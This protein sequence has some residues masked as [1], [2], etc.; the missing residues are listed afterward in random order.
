M[1]KIYR[2]MW[3][4]HNLLWGDLHEPTILLRGMNI[5]FH[6]FLWFIMVG[7]L[8]FIRKR[9]ML[10]KVLNGKW[11][12]NKKWMPCRRIKHGTWYNSQRAGRLSVAN[13]STNW[14]GDLMTKL[15]G[16]KQYWWKKSILKRKVLISMKY[17]HQFLSLFLI[18]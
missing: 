4:C 11:K 13:G 12:W 15:K 9:W 10:L 14:K 8:A 3:K 2:N 18:M 7:K 16:T 5:I 17:F 6:L 1:Q